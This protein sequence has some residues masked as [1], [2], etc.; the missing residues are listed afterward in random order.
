MD[1]LEFSQLLLSS[2]YWSI[3]SHGTIIF[4]QSGMPTIN[5]AM[6]ITSMNVPS[7]VRKTR[8]HVNTV[9]KLQSARFCWINILLVHVITHKIIIRTEN[10]K[11]FLISLR[12]RFWRYF[13]W[14]FLFILYIKCMTCHNYLKK[15]DNRRSMYV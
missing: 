1:A 7:R 6:I 4:P 5:T 10:E 9:K 12:S 14:T 3:Y 8:L 13:L 11:N 2:S 15:I